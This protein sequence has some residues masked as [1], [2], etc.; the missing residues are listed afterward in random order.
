MNVSEQ[1]CN[2]AQALVWA[3]P[4]PTMRLRF[5]T[6]TVLNW[7]APA[8]PGGTANILSVARTSTLVYEPTHLPTLMPTHL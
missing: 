4:G 2:D 8:D 7:D 3:T 6:K 1:D 5:V